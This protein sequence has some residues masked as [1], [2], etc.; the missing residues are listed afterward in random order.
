MIP[1]LL[2]AGMPGAGKTTVGRA[3]AARLGR[4]F[5][6]LDDVIAAEA[7]LSIAAIFALEGE[8]GFRRR[9]AAAVAALVDNL[10]DIDGSRGDD[11]DAGPAAAR[12]VV[13]ALG[14]G[15][16]V[17]AANR[18]V[19]CAAGLVIVLDAPLGVLAARLGRPGEERPLLDDRIRGGDDGSPSAPPSVWPRLARLWGRRRALYGALP[20][21]VR[22]AG[23]DVEAAAAAVVALAEAVAT[24]GRGPSARALW[25]GGAGGGYRVLV[26]PGLLGAIGAIVTAEGGGTGDDEG[27]TARGAANRGATPAVPT[28]TFALVSEAIVEPLHGRT[29]AESLAAAG[30]DVGCVEVLAQGEAA[31]SAAAV[32]QLW[33]A[34]QAAGL[35]RRGHVVA[36]GGGALT[37]VAGFAAATYLRGI[38]W[39]AVPTTLLGIVD[40][41]IGGKT[42]IDRPAGK[43]LAGA[44]HNPRRVI[45][46][47]DALRTLPAD[48]FADGLAEV[49]KAALIGDPALV[50]LLEAHVA[51][52]YDPSAGAA[53]WPSDVLVDVI[54]RAIAVKAAIVARDPREREGGPRVLLNL[55][56]TFAHGIEKASGYAVPHGRAVAVGLVLAARLA[57]RVGVLE[58]GT[59]PGR[60]AALL[61]GLGLPVRLR[62]GGG[63]GSDID[64]V[65]LRAA[66]AADK[67]RVGAELRFV[68][69]A[70]VGDVRVVAGVGEGE[71]T[72]VLAGG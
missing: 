40:A 71:V 61:A 8:A 59:L 72:A 50:T 28:G 16:L 7:G 57:E 49:V 55:G 12:A 22:T 58:D 68:L 62:A 19:L 4:P 9:E 25:V 66:M 10:A 43:N 52:G 60:L 23:R 34:W 45:A 33:D 70:A 38:A 1:P 5:I 21:H 24:D 46:D 36:L 48:V 44:F 54:V 64:A 37:D 30:V 65:A 42:A 56:H 27:A 6:D 29:V 32:E 63:L 14:G 31:K 69:P 26:G 20:W 2:L 53:G 41:A 11:G 3:V 17:D 51:A 39:T 18:D 67:K 47:T 13:V 15:T 35:D